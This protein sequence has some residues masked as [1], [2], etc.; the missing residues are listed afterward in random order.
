MS[1]IQGFRNQCSP[2]NRSA[3]QCTNAS[4]LSSSTFVKTSNRAY[5]T[6]SPTLSMRSVFK[7]SLMRMAISSTQALRQKKI[8]PTSPQTL[9][10]P[11]S[12]ILAPARTALTVT[13]PI[14]HYNG[15]NR[16]LDEFSK[17]TM[18]W[19]Q[20]GSIAEGVA[21]NNQK[22]DNIVFK[23]ALSQGKRSVARETR[24]Q[25]TPKGL[26]YLRVLQITSKSSAKCKFIST[27]KTPNVD[28]STD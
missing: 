27:K 14:V 7:R 22:K 9:D 4:G 12:S 1:H 5:T 6:P 3:R 26:F 18:E 28:S 25:F 19:I 24:T 23:K 21:L 17:E 11:K 20:R 13:R 2:P 8:M 16:S 15:P 10:I